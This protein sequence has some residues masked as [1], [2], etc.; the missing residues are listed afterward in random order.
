VLDASNRFVDYVWSTGDVTPTI[1]A[2]STGVYWVRTTDVFGRVSSDTITVN[3]PYLGINVKDTVICHYSS[4]SV[5]PILN[6]SPYSFLWNTQQTT[7]AIIV[8]TAG[9]YVCS[10]TDTTGCTFI[11]D[12]IHVGVDS[13]G[14]TNLLP[15][16]TNVCSGNLLPIYPGSYIVQTVIWSDNTDTTFVGITTEDYYSVE[17][18]NINGCIANDTAYVHVKATKPTAN[19]S[20]PN[21]C[22][23]TAIPFTDLS[24]PDSNDPIKTWN[25]NFG[26]SGSSAQQNPTFLFFAP[27]DYNV[28]L[29]LTTD[30][31]CT[32]TITKVVTAAIPPIPAFSFPSIV[33]AGTPVTLTD[34]TVFLFGDAIAS[35]I[36][37]FNGIDTITTKNAVY[38]FPS[39]G[40]FSVKLKA[41]SL[42]GCSDTVVQSVD[43]FPPLTAN[44]S[45]ENLCIGDSTVFTDLTASLSIVDWQWN[46]GDFSLPSTAQSPKHKYS[47]PGAYPVVL[48]VQNAIGC[49]DNVSKTINVVTRPVAKF[50]QLVTCED[51]AYAP[52][53]S[54][55][56]NNDTI[57]S[58]KWTMGNTIYTG[59]TPAHIFADTGIYNVK[60]RV[61]TV[62]GCVD[63]TQKSVS[64]KP[65]PK[66][67]F[68][69]APLYGEA[70]VSVSFINQSTNSSF[71]SWNFG[72]GDVST[73]LAPFHTYNANDTFNIQLTAVSSYGCVDS[74]SRSFIVAPTKLDIA[75][76]QVSSSKTLQPDGSYLITAKARV[77]NLGTRIITN[78][79]FYI[80]IGS[81]GVVSEEWVPA[82]PFELGA[83][84]VTFT[85][86]FVVAA[87]NAN[88]YVCVSAVSVNN[89]ETETTT[90]NNSQCST[91]NEG[92][93]LIG[94]TPN[95]MGGQGQL[96][97]VLPKAGQVIIDI[98][99][100]AGQYVVQGLPLDL[101]KGKSN[102]VLPADK[103]CA[104]EYF[105]RVY[106]NDEKVVRK[107]VVA[108]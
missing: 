59:Q 83:I 76:T 48:T 27:G 95:P 2:S 104:A 17:V 63:S 86:Q 5:Q 10:I 24:V 87:E 69:F 45:A 21:V 65:R 103:M 52:L 58:W 79:Q 16:D 9:S 39:Q 98:V 40:S 75:V 37:T 99:D 1:Q 20:A 56:V 6:S 50:G 14:L 7:P 28:T 74:S 29:N 66:A 11:A 36:W 42:S 51:Q 73:D 23:G 49:I 53:D 92:M 43:V 88:S 13:F 85:A 67:M 91:T 22:F 89:G 26:N 44:F 25:W 72:D 90:A 33:C 4:V 35:W 105:I 30:S 61:T 46:F 41:I 68:S 12:S 55:I 54:S 19:F 38:E 31:G 101:P 96:G 34:Q 3:I 18:M 106:H 97:I 8:N 94:P 57:A 15:S 81:G 60:L 70:P 32:G 80:T 102:Y 107:F 62:N 78:A 71:Y 82:V 108:K 93:Q 100:M 47:T 64:V 77:A 84:D